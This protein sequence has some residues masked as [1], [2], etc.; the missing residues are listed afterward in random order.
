MLMPC[1]MMVER[2]RG[3]KPLI[4]PIG[5]GWESGHTYNA[6]AVRLTGADEALTRALL[7]GEAP[8][9]GIV[10]VFYRAQPRHS[11]G[12][13]APRS[14]VGLALFT[15]DLELIRRLPNPVLLPSDNPRAYDH[16][17]VEDPRVT[18]L[19]DAFY[20]VYCGYTALAGGRT[21]TQVC[22]ARSTDLLHWEKLGPVP[23]EVNTAP[24]KDGVL[25]PERVDGYHLLLH[26]P[27]QG[28]PADYCIELAASRSLTG[29]WRNLGKILRAPANPACRYSWVGAGSVPLPLGDGRYLVIYHT[30]HRLRCGS[31]QYTADAAVFNLRRFSPD[32]PQAVV[33]RTLE[34]ILVPETPFERDEAPGPDPLHCVFPCGTYE[35]RGQIHIIYGGRDAYVL[36]ARLPKAA[37][38]ERLAAGDN[39]RE[40]LRA[41]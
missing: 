1:G 37:L 2:M 33:E 29:E 19:E 35:H 18:R 8:A 16:F 30:G 28:H 36:G 40:E 15:P 38:L 22:L 10:A 14:S 12:F 4:A 41:A 6:A 31:R 26:R 34:R 13:R 17:G 7:G 24:N 21:S 5:E 39:T 25:F 32:Q 23:G 11:P 3:G 9:E 27:M 20:L